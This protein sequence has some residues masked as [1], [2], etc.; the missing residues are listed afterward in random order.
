MDIDELNWEAESRRALR[1]G[2]E[3]RATVKAR[4]HHEAREKAARKLGFISP[5][6]PRFI[7]APTWGDQDT[8][9]ASSGA[10]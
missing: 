9:V 10:R 1:R 5:Y 2:F 7:V 3:D 4:T 8:L 6:D